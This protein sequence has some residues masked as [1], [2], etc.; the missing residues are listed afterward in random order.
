M[1]SILACYYDYPTSSDW[2]QTRIGP[3]HCYCIYAYGHSSSLLLLLIRSSAAV[4]PLLHTKTNTSSLAY[5][6]SS[7]ADVGDTT[8]YL[9]QCRT[10]KM[11]SGTSQTQKDQWKPAF[12][13]KVR[14]GA[15]SPKLGHDSPLVD[16]W[17]RRVSPWDVFSWS[18]I[19]RASHHIS[20]TYGVLTRYELCIENAS[21]LGLQRK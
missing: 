11:T 18:L 5:I 13:M 12:R 4:L 7:A 10:G 19:V 9:K 14:L 16:Q 2:R 6:R 21:H 8:S 15:Y 17:K 20:D 1:S 3:Y